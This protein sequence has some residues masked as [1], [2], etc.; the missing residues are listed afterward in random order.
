MGRLPLK[1]YNE[2][3]TGY[4][5]S[6]QRTLAYY[7]RAQALKALEEYDQAVESLQKH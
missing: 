5:E 3:I 4:P 6:K 1:N 2:L 7:S